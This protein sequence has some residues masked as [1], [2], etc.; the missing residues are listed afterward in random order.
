M[1]REKQ[2]IFRHTYKNYHQKHI[3]SDAFMQNLWEK[4]CADIFCEAFPIKT[5]FFAKD[6]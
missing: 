6:I 3:E 2:L 5:I 4:K 1:K